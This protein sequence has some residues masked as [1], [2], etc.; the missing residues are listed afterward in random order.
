MTNPEL[1]QKNE[2]EK[3]NNEK[4]TSK[5]FLS[6]DINDILSDL[7]KD[8]NEEEEKKENED[9]NEKKEKENEIKEEL[10]KEN[11]YPSNRIELLDYFLSF[12]ETDSELNYV[13]AGYFSKFL[14]IL[15]NKKPIT[16]TN[17]FYNERKDSKIYLSFL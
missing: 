12:V 6:K 10:K 3:M 5:D 17:Y 13:L 2:K 11:D 7:D 4:N 16:L 15:F 9:K 1:K 8:K 14:I